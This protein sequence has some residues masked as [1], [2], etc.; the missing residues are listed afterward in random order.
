MLVPKRIILAAGL[1]LLLNTAA[2][3]STPSYPT[4]FG[5]RVHQ[6]KVQLTE[7]GHTRIQTQTLT[8][9][10]QETLRRDVQ[11]LARTL[12]HMRSEGTLN[13]QA[14]LPVITY[15]NKRLQYEIWHHNIRLMRLDK[16]WKKSG[17]SNLSCLVR[18]TNRLRK[19]TGAASITTAHVR[20]NIS[21]QEGQASWYGGFFHGRRTANGERYDINKLTAAHKKLPFGT[22]VLVTN[23]ATQKSVVVKINDRG[24]FVGERIID[25][26]PEAFKRIGNLGQGVMSVKLTILNDNA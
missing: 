25:L 21:H 6:H 4:V 13:P 3:A 10:H 19:D 22:R 11:Y 18:L 16:S 26:S 23:T 8:P 1:G 7:D 9:T 17:E 15:Q 12:N 24:P 2:Q 5:Y 14:I 20:S